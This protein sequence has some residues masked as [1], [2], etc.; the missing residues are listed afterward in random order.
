[1]MVLP[2][3]AEK[4]NSDNNPDD[5][6]DSRPHPDPN[7]CLNG[8]HLGVNQGY[9]KDGKEDL[10]ETKGQMLLSPPGFLTLCLHKNI[11]I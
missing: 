4:D 5:D 8:Q 1:M 11:P 2:A 10:E 9:D 6:E 7:H 3:A